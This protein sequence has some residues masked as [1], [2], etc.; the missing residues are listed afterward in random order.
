MPYGYEHRLNTGSSPYNGADGFFMVHEREM[1]AALG[2]RFLILP[3]LPGFGTADGRK[4]GK[5]SDMAGNSQTTGMGDT[6]TVENK[7]I[8]F[9]IKPVR[10]SRITGPSRKLNRPG[11]YGH[12]T[13][14]VAV[15]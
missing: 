1:T 8:R 4:I 9:T 15:A 14:L 12:V 5:Q 2:I 13:R 6:L 11:I 10:A 7:Q 3:T